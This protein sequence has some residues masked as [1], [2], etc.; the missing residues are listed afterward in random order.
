[1]QR[2]LRARP[3]HGKGLGGFDP[4]SHHV[5]ATQDHERVDADGADDTDD[6]DSV[7][8]VGRVLDLNQVDGPACVVVLPVRFRR[9]RATPEHG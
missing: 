3:L 1:M 7:V 5:C 4:S 6:A 2:L 8:D 9:G